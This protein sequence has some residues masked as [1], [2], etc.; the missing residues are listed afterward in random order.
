MTFLDKV[1]GIIPTI[2][3][4][5]KV[6]TIKQKLLWTLIVLVIFFLL[7]TVALL[8]VQ[9]TADL[10]RLQVI[11]ASNIGTLLTLG[12]GPI[13]V[14]S[15]ILQLL[16]GIKIINFDF[17]NKQERARFSGLQ[18]I[19]AI[20]IAVVEAIVM[21]K[22]G[23]LTPMPGMFL[24]VVLQIVFGAI[25]VIYLDDIVNKYGIGSGIGL[26]IAA[27][28]SQS[29]LW[30]IFSIPISGLPGSG[31]LLFLGFTLLSSGS[32]IELLRFVLVPILMTLVVFFAVLYAESLHINI[33]LTVGRSGMGAKYPVKFLYV[34]VMPVI[35]ASTLFVNISLLTR[36]LPRTAFVNFIDVFLN[37]PHTLVETMFANGFSFLL[38]LQGFGYMILF[39]GACVI[40]GK[41]WVEVGGQ[42]VENVAKQLQSSGMSIPGFRRD[43][44][45]IVGVLNRYI[46]TIVI[47]G[48]MFVGFLA[49]FSDLTGAIGTGT[50]VLL[51]VGVIYRFYEQLAKEQAFESSSMLKQLIGK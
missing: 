35:L 37:T 22:F 31:G 33:P 38:L 12:I 26:F 25:L 43:E 39:V 7:G 19:L 18:T 41:F 21:T 49:F 8:G 20:V 10:G 45:V 14:A 3:A 2:K 5:A 27:G 40:F 16:A 36:M 6:P 4:P 1:I 23:L 28:V 15:I 30:R 48:S 34:S 13:V 50:G 42:G 9:A 11:L 46:P 32:T 51:T 29:I 44:R 24:F 17:S 47:L